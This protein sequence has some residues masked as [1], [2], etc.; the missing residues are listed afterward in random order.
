M[1]V[2]AKATPLPGR[3]SQPFIAADVGGTHVRIGLVQAGATTGAPLQV[4]AYSKFR[5]ADY[6]GLADIIEEFRAGLDGSARAGASRP[7][8]TS[9]V[10]VE[11]G[12]SGWLS[13]AGA[14]ERP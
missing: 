8:S 5:C 9:G 3:T 12:L 2:A 1:S 6:A 10:P 13:R 11:P 7:G 14:L 4:L